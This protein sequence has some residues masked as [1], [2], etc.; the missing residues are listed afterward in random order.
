V[1][2]SH[3]PDVLPVA[4]QKGYQVMLAGHTHGGQVNIEILG[5]DLNIARF[6]TPFVKGL[7]RH[8]NAL[9]YVNRGI[10]TI[11]MPARLG[12]RPEVAILKLCAI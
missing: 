10:G 12:V 8:G 6:Y 2:L 1:L 3:N 7:Y 11:G 9:G 4:D 5:N